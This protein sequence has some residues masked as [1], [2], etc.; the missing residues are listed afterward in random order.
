VIFKLDQPADI[1]IKGNDR[2]YEVII[3]TNSKPIKPKL[4][5]N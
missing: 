4:E 5:T 2:G 3:D 1:F